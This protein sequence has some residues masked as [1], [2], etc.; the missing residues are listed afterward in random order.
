MDL[1]KLLDRT[2]T[3]A[4]NLIPKPSWVAEDFCHY[5]TLQGLIGMIENNEIWL[6]DHRF[7]NDQ[8]EYTYGKQVSVGAITKRMDAETDISFKKFL[9]KVLEHIGKA[10]SPGIY[11]ASMSFSPDKLDQ[12]KGYGKN[13]ESVCIVFKGDLD[14]WNTGNSHPTAIRQQ[15]VIYSESEQISM[16][17]TLI[18]VYKTN[19]NDGIKDFDY[20]FVSEL[21]WLIESRFITFKHNEYS[22]ENEVRLTI[23]NL[24]HILK[25]KKP[26]YRIYNGMIVPYITTKY[27]STDN[28]PKLI[29]LPIKKIIVNPTSQPDL[30]GGIE[31]F[32]A[33][34]G[35]N[36]IEVKPSII[37][38][39]G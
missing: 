28:N 37:K 12:W 4:F 23:E 20:P 31:C 29:Q 38:F 27:I 39:R 11:V 6:S 19:F 35:Y 36:D 18:N 1:G 17:E 8:L 2:S 15:K 5:T 16:I 14:L 13:K 30:I 26:K 3:E 33:D 22:A 32:V 24:G 9:S 10:S 7:L 34:M 21:A 25:S